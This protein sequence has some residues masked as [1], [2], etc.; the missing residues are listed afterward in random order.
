MRITPRT[1]ATQ[2]GWPEAVT[3]AAIGTRTRDAAPRLT[4]RQV[5]AGS[6]YH[7]AL[8][9]GR[10][11]PRTDLHTHDFFEMMY[12]LAGRGAHTVNRQTL[13]LRAGDL[14]LIRP[15]DCHAIVSQPGSELQFVNVAF[16]GDS[17]IAFC[18]LAGISGDTWSTQHSPLP[19]AIQAPAERR[20]ECARAFRRAL[21]AFHSGA[22]ALELCGFWV[23]TLPYLLPAGTATDE[24]D[25]AMPPWLRS[26]CWAMR[27][28]ANLRIGLARFVELSGVGPAHLARTLKA[29]RGET[30]TA[31]VNRL[32]VERAA[33]LL[34]TT[35]D[36]IGEVSAACGFG[37]LSHFYR[38]FGLR[39]GQTPRAYRLQA[40]RVIAPAG[41]MSAG[42]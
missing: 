17:W 5:G 13:P 23:Q 10:L 27:D 42:R 41:A 14:L 4:W 3:V 33:L 36:A 37:A 8:V 34:A 1:V 18:A 32:R 7:A 35:D 25:G 16:P 29:C 24:E 15:D 40:Q 22:S 2:C 39:Y 28:E 21:F 9:R 6:P 20:D 30:P 31:F 26:A 38:L 11:V 19:P 12:V